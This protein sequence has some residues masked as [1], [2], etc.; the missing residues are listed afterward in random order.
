MQR[1][2]LGRWLGC[3]GGGLAVLAASCD[4]ASWDEHASTPVVSK[5]EEIIG[6]F[7]ANNSAL[8]AVGSLNIHY[9][10]GYSEYFC[11][12]VLVT[13][14]MVLTARQCAERL[15]YGLG[16]DARPVFAIGPS[17][18]EPARQVDVVHHE[19]PPASSDP[20][21][22]YDV[23]VL[24]LGEA[25]T[26]VPPLPWAAIDESTLGE[27]FV[28]LGYGIQGT[29]YAT[30][31]RKLGSLTLRATSGR[32]YEAIF[33]SFEAY[34][35]WN[36]GSDLPSD[37]EPR[38]EYDAG[39]PLPSGG[40]GGRGG[41]GGKGGYGGYPP[42]N[43]LCDAA[44]YLRENYDNVRLEPSALAFAG[45]LSGE[46]QPCD[47]DA[48]GP[49]LRMNEAGQLT[50]YAILSGGIYANAPNK[51]CDYGATY[52]A[53]DQTMLDFI[54]HAKGWV[55]PCAGLDSV[56][57]CSGSVAER[58]SGFGEGDRRR[59][60]FDCADVG[61]SCETQNDGS[62]GCGADDSY[63]P[64]RPIIDQAAAPDVNS[65]VFRSPMYP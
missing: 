49:L 60:V 22:S 59:L 15:A 10:W 48:G 16:S 23:A 2:M 35:K 51:I 32:M 18:R 19:L 20:Y 3:V 46:A 26:D 44:I 31:T 21:T 56:G 62:I 63:F 6:G 29:N 7:G 8:N 27:K 61:L 4:S 55:D 57:R 64:A 5:T 65:Q 42:Y 33:G 12:A 11:T 40:S 39:I 47:G 43:W 25:I 54:E 45:G 9:T 1:Q 41:A 34:F 38:N 17:A 13:E 50:V 28:G 30:G 53:F 36:T 58:C 37:C 52:S 24:H 14:N